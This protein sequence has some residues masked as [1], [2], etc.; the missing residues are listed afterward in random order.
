MQDIAPGS[1]S[2]TG[3]HSIADFNE[4][5]RGSRHRLLCGI[6]LGWI[7]SAP[8]LAQAQ[9]SPT[10]LSSGASI[11]RLLEETRYQKAYLDIID[12][13][14][15]YLLLVI[16]RAIAQYTPVGEN[17]RLVDEF[18]SRLV[19]AFN[20][21]LGWDNMKSLISESYRQYSQDEVDAMTAFYASEVGEAIARKN[22]GLPQ[23][24]DKGKTDRWAAVRQSQGDTAFHEAVR[25]DLKSAIADPLNDS[26]IDAMFS[27]WRSAV[28]QR[29]QSGWPA[30]C[31]NI[32][33]EFH[34]RQQ[35]FLAQMRPLAQEYEA[36]EQSVAR[37]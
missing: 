19:T 35:E 7:V 8:A 28:G 21:E 11:Q 27:F 16:D 15:E 34:K 10:P 36:R 6:V 5:R 29:I 13:A 22:P 14:N 12:A 4:P 20:E 1:N 17:K 24:L 31:V 30:I 18:K 33:A 26:E 23:F 37:N 2:G 25:A 32:S 3:W 9:P